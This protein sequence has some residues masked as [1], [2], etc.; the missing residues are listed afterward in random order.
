MGREEQQAKTGAWASPLFDTGRRKEAWEGDAEVP[1]SERGLWEARLHRVHSG[2]QAGGCKEE[3]K[4]PTCP[5]TCFCPGAVK[6]RRLVEWLASCPFQP[7]KPV[8]TLP[9]TPCVPLSH[10]SQQNQP[11]PQK[12][13][14]RSAVVR[15]GQVCIPQFCGGGEP[16]RVASRGLGEASSEPSRRPFSTLPLSKGRQGRTCFYK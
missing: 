16:G 15:A 11:R 13:E 7:R 2:E 5:C 6:Q 3:L 12:E 9:S 4:L 10:L 8:P 14:L 1:E